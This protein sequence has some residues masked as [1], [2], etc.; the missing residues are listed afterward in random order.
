MDGNWREG[1]ERGVNGSTVQ[2]YHNSTVL[3][4]TL[5]HHNSNSKPEMQ[6]S[7][8]IRTSVN[9]TWHDFAL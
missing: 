2:S 1:L 8:Q 4:A 7:S 5:R 6:F 9:R 3:P